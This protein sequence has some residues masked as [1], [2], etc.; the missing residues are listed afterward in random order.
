MV[1][2][3]GCPA[4]LARGGFR[5]KVR[6]EK[7]RPPMIFPRAPDVTEVFRQ[8]EVI[9]EGVFLCGAW[10]KGFSA[11]HIGGGGWPGDP[12]SEA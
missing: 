5:L 6:A 7:I 4:R 1:L 10:D 12:R 2:K 3:G 8:A 9:E 11:G